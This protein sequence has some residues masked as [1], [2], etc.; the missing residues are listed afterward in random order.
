MTTVLTVPAAPGARD[1]LSARRSRRMARVPWTG[2]AL[3]VPLALLI[4][5]PLAYLAAQGAELGVTEFAGRARE[6]GILGVMGNVLLLAI[7]T[8]G[9]CLLTAVPLAWLVVRSDMPGRAIVRVLAPLPLALPPY[10][11]AI[12]YQL[13]MAPSGLLGSLATRWLGL[14][15]PAVAS[16]IYGVWGAAWVLTLFTFPYVYLLAS[17]ALEGANPSIEEAARAAGMPGRE[18]FW[19][20]TLPLLRPA[21]LGGGLMVFLYAWA[22]FGVV[23]LLRMRTLTTVIYDYIQGTMDWGI[24]AG[25]SLILTLITGLALM[26]QLRILGRAGYTQ[27]TGSVKPA[28]PVALG[29]WRPLALLFAVVLLGASLAVPLTVLAVQS[30]RLGGAGIVRLALEQGRFIVHSLGTALGGATLIM[31][32]A[33]LAAWLEARRRQPRLL[34]FLVQIA[35]AIPGTVLGLGMVGFLSAALPVV[36][37][38]PSVVVL[39]YVVLFLA[40][41]L[42]AV[43]AALAQL[44]AS[45]EEAARGLGRTPLQAFRAVTFPLLR[46]GL[47]G[48][49]ILIFMLCM[50][51]L[52]ATLVLRPPGFDTLPVRVWI[53]TMDVGPEPAAAALAL[54]LVALVAVPWLLLL[55]V[56]RRMA[57]GW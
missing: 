13:L 9:F 53:H 20:V 46:P 24:P 2:L 18:V 51:E 11:G 30:A 57:V 45:L 7:L 3:G 14:T 32:L 28:Q 52:S 19:R 6:L 1:E 17:A 8:T 4:V 35:Y 23:S 15:P 21:L 39:G 25:L 42:Q 36:Y 49:W 27:I 12:V 33:F 37:G 54:L 16:L 29:R 40:P 10:I 22:D 56:R 41:A 5:G 38:R 55:L 43:K 34:S 48:G 26:A 44:D 47:V 50:R 31:V